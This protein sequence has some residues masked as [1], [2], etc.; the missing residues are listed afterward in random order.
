MQTDTRHA[1]D[2]YFNQLSLVQEKYRA[3]SITSSISSVIAIS[4]VV[5]RIQFNSIQ[6][7]IKL[8]LQLN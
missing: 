6:L 3:C 7:V 2:S 8:V 4:S 5:Q 1:L